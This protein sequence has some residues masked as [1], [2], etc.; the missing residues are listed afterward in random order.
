MSSS[1]PLAHEKDSRELAL[2]TWYDDRVPLS[3]SMNHQVVSLCIDLGL[4]RAVSAKTSPRWVAIVAGRM[5]TV[6]RWLFLETAPRFSF[7]MTFH[8]GTSHATI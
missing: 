2:I 6:G 7:G 1:G 5:P 4:F 8:L 3:S